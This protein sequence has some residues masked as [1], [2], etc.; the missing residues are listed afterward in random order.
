MIWSSGL[1]AITHASARPLNVAGRASSIFAPA[2]FEART[3]YVV[4]QERMCSLGGAYGICS[5]FGVIGT[6]FAQFTTA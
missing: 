4:P 2:R 5:V 3:R 1:D 6:T